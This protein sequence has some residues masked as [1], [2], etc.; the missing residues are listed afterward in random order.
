MMIGEMIKNSMAPRS[1]QPSRHQRTP[2]LPT[3]VLIL[4]LTVLS[5][6][7]AGLKSQAANWYVDNA[8]TGANQGTNWANAWTDLTKVVWGGRGV[9]PGDTLHISGG[10]T[11]KTYTNFWSVTVHGTAENRITIRVGQDAGHNGHVYFDGA[12]H[13]DTFPVGQFTSLGRNY[14]TL[15]GSVNGANRMSY[16]NI[17][18]TNS[19]SY[20]YSVL[21]SSTAECSVRFVNFSNVNNGIKLGSGDGSAIHNCNFTVR[22]DSAIMQTA[23]GTG[24]DKILLY[25]NNVTVWVKP[26]GGGPDGFQVRPGTS[27][28]NNRFRAESVD[29]YTSGQHPDFIQGLDPRW[30]KFY[31]NECVNFGDAGVTLAPFYGTNGLQD[32]LI[33]NNI[34]R[35]TTLIDNVPEYI[36]FL[37]VDKT[38]NGFY[39]NVYIVNNLF[40]DG[41][42]ANTSILTTYREVAN[43]GVQ[44]TNNWIA[45]NIWVGS[46]RNAYNPMFNIWFTNNP[47]VWTITNNIYNPRPGSV[48]HVTYYGTNKTVTDFIANYDPSGTTSLPQFVRYVPHAEANDFRLQAGDDV[49]RDK[50]LD[51]SHLFTSDYDGNHRAGKWNIGPYQFQHSTKAPSP[52]TDLRLPFPN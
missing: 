17:V 5:F 4:G 13:G 3:G 2:T 51:F 32:I 46:S 48:G 23:D 7:N 38:Y 27:V 22:G 9:V 42:N 41:T 35:Q 26:G 34:F 11:S 16:V 1:F 24:W 52:P 43:A 29:L 50:G 25:S 10:S 28:F 19:R 31:G 8:A 14:L 18:N 44:G 12:L 15:D 36:R 49:A 33:F 45:N 37:T 20:G 21:S 39:K 6:L 40:A 47:S 30:F